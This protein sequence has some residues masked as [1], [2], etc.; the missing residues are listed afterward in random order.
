MGPDNNE[1]E[2]ILP[3]AAFGTP[4]KQVC[5]SEGSGH[6]TQQL[7]HSCL[8]EWWVALELTQNWSSFSK[9]TLR[10]S[11]PASVRACQSSIEI[12]IIRW[13]LQ[14]PV[15]FDIQIYESDALSAHFGHI[16]Q[17]PPNSSTVETPARREY[18][19]IRLVDTG[20][21]TP[22]WKSLS[23]NSGHAP[24][25]SSPRPVPFILILEPLYF[26]VL[27]PSVVPLLWY[28]LLVVAVAAFAVPRIQRYLLHVAS[29][30]NDELE[31]GFSTDVTRAKKE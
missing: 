23:Q 6:G 10:L 2:W 22:T 19:R 3:P 31:H 28:I 11:W 7:G 29:Q 27:P 14:F 15:D 8:H 18:A 16:E 12:S 25:R 21:F 1:H 5:N 9:F 30:A 24:S 26:G 20:V 4:L 13:L 17:R